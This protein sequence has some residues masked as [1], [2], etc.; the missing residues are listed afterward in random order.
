M[1]LYM[2]IFKVRFPDLSQFGY[3][4]L[5]FSGLVPYLA[6]MECV[7][8]ATSSIRQN[9]HLVKNV[10]IPIELIPAR[11]A[12]MSVVAQVP[13]I[14]LLIVMAYLNDTLTF[15]A[16]FLPIAV[17]VQLLLLLGLAYTM[18][19]L[20]GLFPDLA[21]VINIV[22][23][24]LLFVSPIAFPLSAAPD[25]AMVAL[26]LNPVTHLIELFRPLVVGADQIDWVANAAFFGGA[27][28]FCLLSM[29]FFRRFKAYVI[30]HE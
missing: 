22:L 15:N 17:F 27:T 10:M 5:V 28:L 26:Q 1:F 29:G 12:L 9:I 7:S 4:V 16:L 14:F 3:V 24:F 6:L 19:A 18:S 23:I 30:D 2:V 21:S 25:E 20:G 8:S 11:I 13:G